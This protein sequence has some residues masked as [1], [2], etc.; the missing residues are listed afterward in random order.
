MTEGA[1]DS[2]MSN[3]AQKNFSK[4]C[5]TG[6]SEFAAISIDGGPAVGAARGRISRPALNIEATGPRRL[7]VVLVLAALL[8]MNNNT[9]A[10]ADL[11][12]EAVNYVFTGKT[13]PAD[14][15]EIVDR[16]SCI[17]VMRDPK[18]P[19]YIRYY[20]SRF[21]MDTANFQ[22]I[23]AGS[24]TLYNLEVANDDILLEYLNIDKTT[25]TERYRS[26]QI[27]LPGN[28][29]QTQKALRIIFADHCKADQTKTPF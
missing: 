26:A 10:Q 1:S 4:K 7:A 22:K 27:P 19:R 17:V 13:D 6:S 23:Y 2:A 25:V 16:N 3:R 20:L 14:A 11:F 21:K 18:Y 8:S 12:Q 9:V 24:Q 28:I 5:S 15:P 29:D